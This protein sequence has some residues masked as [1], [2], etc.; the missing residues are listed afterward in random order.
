MFKQE[1]VWQRLGHDILHIGHN[2]LNAKRVQCQ[3][4]NG[5]TELGEMK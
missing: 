5:N 2:I 3:R 1:F 4:A